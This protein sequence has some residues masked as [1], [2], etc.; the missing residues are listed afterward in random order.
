M[1]ARFCAPILSVL[2]LLG[3]SAIPT[4]GQWQEK[5]LWQPY[6]ISPRS[7]PQHVSLGGKWDLG[8]R[9]TPISGF[10]DLSEQPKWTSAQVPSSVQWAL[11]RAGELPHPY[12]HLNS[13]KYNWVPDKVWYYRR[14]FQ[15]PSSVQGQYVFLCFDGLG[16]YSKIWLNGELLGRHA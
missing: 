14:Q 15:V 2:V 9:D 10:E 7:G 11:Y 1:K 3:I 12:Y 13:K 8:Y 5:P 6:Y 16:Y 4:S